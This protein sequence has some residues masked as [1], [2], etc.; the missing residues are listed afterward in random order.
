[1]SVDD[2]QTSID[3]TQSTAGADPPTTTDL[4]PALDR[5]HPLAYSDHTTS[6]P[7][8][9]Y[10]PPRGLPVWVAA[11]V[12]VVAALAVAAA[13]FALGRTTAPSAAPANPDPEFQITPWTDPSA[14]TTTTRLPAPPVSQSATTA[15]Q[16]PPAAPPVPTPV[17]PTVTVT[18]RAIPQVAC[19]TLRRYPSMTINDVAMM[20]VEDM[21]LGISFSDAKLRVVD[22]VGTSCPD[23]AR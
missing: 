12:L 3:A 6:V 23:L 17:P 21:A 5:D 13:T 16:S 11:L 15:T 18:T 20:M 4:G 10:Q 22:E 19:D 14:T 2:D 8:I 7:V 9:D 1:M